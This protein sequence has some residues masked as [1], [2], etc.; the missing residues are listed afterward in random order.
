MGWELAVTLVVVAVLIGAVTDI[1]HK[2]R[3]KRA[4]ERRLTAAIDRAELRIQRE[5]NHQ[6]PAND[7]GGRITRVIDPNGEQ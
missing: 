1:I 6:L 7:Q 2:R 4:L 5:R 3:R